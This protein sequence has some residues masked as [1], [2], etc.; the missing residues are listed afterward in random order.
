[1]ETKDDFRNEHRRLDEEGRQV[2]KENRSGTNNRI[3][4]GVVLVFAGLFLVIRNTGFFPDFIDNV[5]FS[6]PM[7]LVAI[8]L[9]MTLGSTEKTGGII[10]MAV[11]GFFMIPLLFRETFHM[12]NMFWPSIFI[13]VGVIFIVSRRRGWNA[14]TTK[15]VI[16]DDWVDYVNVFSGGERQIVSQNF[17]GGKITA[18]FGGIELD[19]TKA[20]LAPG[21]SYLE[22]ACVFGGATLI[23][24]DDWHITIEVTPVLGGFTDSR[25]LSPGRTVDPSKHL[26]VKGAVVFGGGEVKSY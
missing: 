7:L 19:L 4:I 16:G 22:I 25:K 9:V 23:V 21:I 26:V 15:G 20:G 5:I 18:I 3:L 17:K 12:Y 8:G 6:W 1:M 14:V 11:G 2:P 13:I 10:V 24:P